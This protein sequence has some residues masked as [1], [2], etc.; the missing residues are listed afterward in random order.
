MYSLLFK[1]RDGL[2]PARFGHG[3]GDPVTGVQRVQREAGWRFKLFGSASG[4]RAGGAALRLSNRDGAID[5]VDLG[6]RSRQRLLG[7]SRRADKGNGKSSSQNHLCDFHG[8]PSAFPAGISPAA[9]FCSRI[10]TRMFHAA[11]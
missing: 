6:N 9:G 4:V 10:G 5:P 7:Q 1:L 11:V 2:D 8:G 3:K